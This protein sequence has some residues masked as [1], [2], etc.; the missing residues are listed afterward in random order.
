MDGDYMDNEQISI[1]RIIDGQI[2]D[3]PCCMLSSK[4]MTKQIIS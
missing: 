1:D 2:N 3:R 4:L